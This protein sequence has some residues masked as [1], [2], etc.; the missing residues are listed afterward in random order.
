MVELW[1]KIVKLY[2]SLSKHV[3]ESHAAVHTRSSP[4]SVLGC[5]ALLQVMFIHSVMHCFVGATDIGAKGQ[6]LPTVLG[7]LV[8]RFSCR[9][10]PFPVGIRRINISVFSYVLLTETVYYVNV[11]RIEMCI[12]IIY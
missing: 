8:D 4:T 5:R 2:I 3:K 6:F 12:V 7:L 1:L 10:L 11:L 9:N